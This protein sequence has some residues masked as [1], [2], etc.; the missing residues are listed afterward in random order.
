MENEPTLTAITSTEVGSYLGNCRWS[1]CS[2]F[3][4]DVCAEFIVCSPLMSLASQR[5]RFYRAAVAS[6]MQQSAFQNVSASIN[7]TVSPPFTAYTAA[8]HAVIGTA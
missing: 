1:K 8:G 4:N 5:E 2:N 6:P 7:A 3:A